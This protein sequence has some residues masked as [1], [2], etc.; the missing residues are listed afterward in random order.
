MMSEA[1]VFP[2]VLVPTL[3][4]LGLLM[5]TEACGSSAQ[6]RRVDA[7]EVCMVNDEFFGTRQLPV[8]VEDRTYFGCCAGCE[9]KIR[10]D[11]RVRAAVDPVSGR[12]V[13]KATAVIGTLPDHKVF[14]FESSENLKKFRISPAS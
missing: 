4:V 13:D 14:Y 3:M 1:R 11:A 8:Q 12:V 7:Q 10:G 6:L 9:K 5:A 2:K